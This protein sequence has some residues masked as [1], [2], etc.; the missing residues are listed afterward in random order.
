MTAAMSGGAA[1]QTGQ[2]WQ[3]AGRLGMMQLVVVEDARVADEATYVDAVKALCAPEQTCFVRFY[4]NPQK[5][6]LTVP[7]PDAIAGAPTAFYSR[8]AKQSNATFQWSCRV[9]NDPGRCF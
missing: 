2:G 8:S 5:L 9:R 3:M 6:P 1:A 4:A 7:L